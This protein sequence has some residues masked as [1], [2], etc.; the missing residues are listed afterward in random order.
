MKWHP[1]G[2]QSF[3]Y[4]LKSLRIL[5]ALTSFRFYTIFKGSGEL[6]STA[7]ATP[8]FSMSSLDLLDGIDCFDGS[9][10]SW[11]A[12]AWLHLKNLVHDANCLF[13]LFLLVL[14]T[15]LLNLKTFTVSVVNFFTVQ[16]GLRVYFE[17]IASRLKCLAF[18]LAF[19]QIYT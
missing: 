4:L 13:G 5:V 11:R 16:N 19:M 9:A 10:Y 6:T 17:K 3:E 7:S 2:Q 15:T 18:G 1:I 14:T 8:K 12:L